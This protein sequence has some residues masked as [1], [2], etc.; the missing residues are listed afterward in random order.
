MGIYSISEVS[1]IGAKLLE[2]KDLSFICF[3]N[4]PPHL[5]QWL[6]PDR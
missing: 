4:P 1:E 3:V 5:A 2:D 6:A